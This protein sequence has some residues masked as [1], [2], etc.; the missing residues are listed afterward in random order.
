[1]KA[2]NLLIIFLLTACSSG[3]SKPL[4]AK[5]SLDSKSDEFRSCFL[6]SN[7][8]RGKDAP[9]RGKVKVSFTIAPDGSATNE[10]IVHSDF[11][12]PNMHACMLDIL[13]DIEFTPHTSAEDGGITNVTQELNFHRKRE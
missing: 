12:D 2:T 11:K 3:P 8:Y 13:R 5:Q 6:E 1:M 7:S 9:D 10:K 4:S